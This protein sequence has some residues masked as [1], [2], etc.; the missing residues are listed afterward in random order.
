MF[1][2][3]S[4]AQLLKRK[5]LN[6]PSSKRIGGGGR[7]SESSLE[8]SPILKRA[9]PCPLFEPTK[10]ADQ[11]QGH[12][13]RLPLL[14]EFEGICHAG[15]TSIDPQHRF[16]FCNRGYAKVSCKVFPMDMAIAAIRFTLM[17]ATPTALSVLAV[18]E[19]DHWP[20]SWRR[21]DFIIGENRLEPEISDICRRAQIFQFCLSYLE[22]N[23]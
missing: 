16:Q 22:K 2:T 14:Y 1:W 13:P 5:I 15:E 8:V 12:A 18:E 11:A 3:H 9:M 23:K 17:R 20:I 21:I 19:E 10:K 4:G 6:C 7:G